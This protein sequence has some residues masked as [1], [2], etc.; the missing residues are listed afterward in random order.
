MNS[1]V[2]SRAAGDLRRHRAHYDVTVMA[3]PLQF[4]TSRLWPGYHCVSVAIEPWTECHDT[5]LVQEEYDCRVVK[6]FK[7][8]KECDRT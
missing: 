7:C 8:L 4:R 3:G 2:N 5:L 1:L 6:I